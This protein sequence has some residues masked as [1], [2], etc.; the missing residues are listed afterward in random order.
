MG[1]G[2]YDE[3]EHE[4]RESKKDIETNSVKSGSTHDGEVSTENADDTDEL[5]NQLQDIKD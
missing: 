3:S 4:T 1:F 2:S 5:L